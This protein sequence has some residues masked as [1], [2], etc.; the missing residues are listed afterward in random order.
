[1]A[2]P[3][4]HGQAEV[5]ID[6]PPETCEQCRFDA[7]QYERRDLVGTIRSLGTLWRWSIEG[8]PA[9]L[10]AQRPA[11]SRPSAFEIGQ[12]LRTDLAGAL[13]LAEPRPWDP[14]PLDAVPDAPP[15]AH[16]GDVAG[17]T[18]TLVSLSATAHGT[19]PSDAAGWKVPV[20]LRGAIADREQAAAH[21]AHRGVHRLRELGRVLHD[22]GAGAPTQAGTVERIN[23]SDGGVPKTAVDEAEVGERG[24]VGDRQAARQHHGR[25]WQ[26]LCL[27]S[28]EVIEAL[29][30]EGH[31]IDAGS[32]GENLTLSG[33]DWSTMRPGTRLLIGEVAAEV[34]SWAPPCKKTAGWFVDGAF[35]RIDHD[36][37]PGWA[38]AYAWVL[39]PGRVRTGDEVI[40]EP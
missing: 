29:Q 36:R 35:S 26:A 7:R 28:S 40:V 14:E 2:Q 8:V 1:V 24:L 27:W 38:R 21:L 6:A 9:E 4:G 15:P 33:L 16:A 31:P 34:A 3:T 18:E 23:V 13:L 30:R 22:L 20:T 5:V 39:E 19:L 12:G 11:P 32:A 25:P 17:L 10:V 37:H